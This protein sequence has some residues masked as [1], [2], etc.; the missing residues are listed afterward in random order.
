M[1]LYSLLADL[2]VVVHLA[3]V[4][5]VL[6]ALPVILFG[7]WRGWEWVR[8]RAFRLMHLA[9]ITIVVVEALL[10]ITCPL[11]TLEDYLRGQAGQQVVQGSFIGRLAHDLLFFDVPQ[12]FFTPI[13]CL[14][15][16]LVVGTLFLVPIRWTKNTEP[17]SQHLASSTD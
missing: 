11:T 13:Y 10:S 5:F 15:G 2:V 14:F 4:L 7:G 12:Q 3:Y 1:N 16:A 17:H 6:L 9:M 8:N